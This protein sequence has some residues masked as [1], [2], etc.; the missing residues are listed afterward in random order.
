MSWPVEYTDEFAAWWET[1]RAGAQDDIAAI[2]AVL[3]QR[4]PRLPFPYGDRISRRLRFAY[5]C[6]RND[7]IEDLFR[8]CGLLRSVVS[9][10]LKEQSHQ[11]KE[12]HA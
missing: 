1:L 6:I 11:L 12:L 8:L 3:E 5:N 2:V 4:G 7:A 10:L 9:G